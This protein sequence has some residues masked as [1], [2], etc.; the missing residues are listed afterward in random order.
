MDVIT[1]KYQSIYNAIASFS[2]SIDEYKKWK[3]DINP[4]KAHSIGADY[5]PILIGLRDSSIQRFEYSV[6]TLWKYLK[7]Y[8]EIKYNIIVTIPA[9]ANIVRESSKL[10]IIT[11]KNAEIVLEMIKSRNMTSHIYQE[12]IAEVLAQSLPAYRDVMQNIIN[13]LKP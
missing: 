5:E 4:Q 10:K 9:P 13:T 8:L 6:D 2:L 11:E 3:N 12:E 7:I 1:K